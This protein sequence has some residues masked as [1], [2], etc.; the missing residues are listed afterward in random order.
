MKKSEI[1][2]Q[3]DYKATT[4][5][6]TASIALTLNTILSNVVNNVDAP[7]VLNS[8][9]AALVS[10]FA[11]FADIMTIRGFLTVDKFCKLSE[12]NQ[13][14]YLGKKLTVMTVV[15]IVVGVILT[16]F[17]IGMSVLIAQYDQLETL[18]HEDETARMNIMILTTIVN[19]VL[20]FVAISTPYIVYVWK[21]R[22]T[23]PAKDKLYNFALLTVIVM[24]VQLAIGIL[25]STYIMRNSDSAF[26]TSFSEILATVKY[27]VLTVFL[28]LRRNSIIASVPD[29]ETK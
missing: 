13:N 8:V 11:I 9:L 1:A 24:V 17:A 20:Q 14:Y 10:I 21:L 6:L 15:F 26:L 25:N 2:R 4:F 28:F 18:T 22:G 12:D 23:I 7:V 3:F 27:L 5:L 19:I 29:D 16:F